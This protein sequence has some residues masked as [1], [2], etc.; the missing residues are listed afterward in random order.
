M[1]TNCHILQD[2]PLHVQWNIGH[3]YDIRVPYQQ[4]GG[5]ICCCYCNHIDMPLQN[6]VVH[7]VLCVIGCIISNACH[8]EQEYQQDGGCSKAGWQPLIWT[9]EGA[10]HSAVLLMSRTKVYFVVKDI[11]SKTHSLTYLDILQMWNW[12]TST[13]LSIT[14][15]AY[16]VLPRNHCKMWQCITAIKD[17]PI[18]LYRNKMFMNYAEKNAYTGA[19]EVK[20]SAYFQWSN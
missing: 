18:S 12:G 3:Q 11:L 13:Q 9:V 4:D 8:A 15:R 16:L 7:F 5:S 2:P 17:V 6:F 1:A 20:S 19:S 10:Y 14:K